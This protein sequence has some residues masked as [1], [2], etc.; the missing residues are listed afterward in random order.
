VITEGRFTDIELGTIVDGNV[1]GPYKEYRI[2]DIA[3]YLLNPN[4]VEIK[5]R[6]VG[7]EIHYKQGILKKVRKSFR[8][9]L[10]NFLKRDKNSSLLSPEVIVSRY[11]LQRPHLLDPH[12]EVHLNHIHDL[13]KSYDT[14]IKR[15]AQ[16]DPHKIF[17]IVGICEDIGGNYSYLKLQGTIEEKIK[18]LSN[19]VSK[20][21][22]VIISKAYI[23][24]GLFELRGYDFLSYDPS[25]SFRLVSYFDDGEQ[26]ACILTDHNK[27]DFHL[28]DCHHIKQM[29][30]LDHSLKA[31]SGLIKAFNM[32]VEGQATAIKLFFNSKLEI[33]YSKTTLPSIYLDLFRTL[34]VALDQRNQIKSI[35][36]YL[37][38]G[39][40]LNYVLQADYHEEKML[41]NISVLHD[42][43]ALEPLRKNLPNV[44]SAMLKKAFI[45]EAGRYYLLDTINGYGN[46]Q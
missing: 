5:K 43:R 16:L 26:K 33:D 30:L 8:K 6:L 4:P 34:N 41:T 17:Q 46:A 2:S 20:E 15:L 45:S 3:R 7:G 9:V 21:V 19:F 18:Y 12:L 37:Q 29:H 32:F 23:A 24:D 38:T 10:P 40:S 35:L 27:I 13:L 42:F 44:Y 14:A 36:N 39:V 28:S 1:A 22:G 25:K 31:N 11:K